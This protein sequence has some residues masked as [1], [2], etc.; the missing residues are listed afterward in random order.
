MEKINNQLQKLNSQLEKLQISLNMIAEIK[1]APNYKD[2]QKEI[3]DLKLQ[4][5]QMLMTDLKL[6]L[7]QTLITK[8][9][10]CS[11]PLWYFLKNDVDP[12]EGRTYW[13][14]KC[15][16]CEKVEER[17]NRDFDD[18]VIVGDVF[19]GNGEKSPHTYKEVQKLYNCKINSK[20]NPKEEL[21]KTLIKSI[22]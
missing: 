20:S 5:N 18:N 8:Q 7:K 3:D 16:E 9:N 15:L 14:C 1:V 12:H 6:E 4:L 11:H 2:L 19:F 22:K 13:T 10:N 17:R 21:C